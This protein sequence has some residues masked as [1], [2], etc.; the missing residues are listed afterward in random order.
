MRNNGHFKL[1]GYS[2][3]DWAGNTIDR[4]FNTGFCTFVVGNLVTWKSKKQ[5]L[6]AR[7]SAEVEYRAMTYTTCELTWLKTLL[8]DLGIECTKPITSH[9]DNQAAMHIAANPVL[10]ER[11]KHIEIDCHFIRDQVHSKVLTTTYV[12]SGDQLADILI[13][14]LPTAQF[15]RLLSKL[16]SRRYLI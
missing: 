16:G 12:R 6:V 2:D 13:K 1:E 8:K 4:K 15:D 11:T 5:N 9:C 10:H 3:S 14:V 7:S